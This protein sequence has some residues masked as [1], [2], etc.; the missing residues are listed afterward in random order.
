MF[1]ACNASTFKVRLR[2]FSSRGTAGAGA[3]AAKDDDDAPAAST[4]TADRVSSAAAE[5]FVALCARIIGGTPEGGASDAPSA[6]KD[7]RVSPGAADLIFEDA[8]FCAR[9]IGGTTEEGAVEEAPLLLL[10][11]LRAPPPRVTPSRLL[12]S[13]LSVLHTSPL[14][15]VSLRT[16]R[17]DEAQ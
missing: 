10:R 14:I 16:N 15:E 2:A 13:A 3:G 4:T 17:Q 5:R 9:I 6:A 12:S 8:A 11:T 1:A 7:A